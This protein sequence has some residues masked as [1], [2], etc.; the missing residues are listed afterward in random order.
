MGWEGWGEGRVAGGGGQGFH[1]RL[2]IKCYV[3]GALE[4]SF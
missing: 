2:Q 1:L 4:F 3:D